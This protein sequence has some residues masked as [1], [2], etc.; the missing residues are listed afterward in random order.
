MQRRTFIQVVTAAFLGTSANVRDAYSFSRPKTNFRHG[1]ASG[2][3]THDGVIIWTRVTTSTVGTAN[4]RWQVASDIGMRKVVRD[5]TFE[6][7]ESRDFTVKVDVDGL[8]AGN[9][10]FYRF[11]CDGQSSTVGKTRTLPRGPVNQARFAVVSCSNYPAGYFN[12][13]REIAL[14]DDLDAVLHLGDYIYEYGMGEYATENAESLGRVPEPR[15]EI[16]TLADYRQRHAQYKTDPDSQS[17][18]A[19]LPVIAIW[20]DHEFANDSWRDGAQNHQPDEGGWQSRRDAA[21]QAYFEWM[22]VRGAADGAAT[23]IYR[24]FRWGDLA[25]IFMLD[26]RLVGRDAQPNAGNEVSRDSIVAPDSAKQRRLLGVEQEDW[27]RTSLKGATDTAWQLIG[28]QVMVS[29]MET[30][31]LEPLV[32]RERSP[33]FSPEQMDDVI[34][35]SKSHAPQVLDVWEGYPIAREDFLRD[36]DEYAVNP[37]VLSGDFHTSMAG[38]LVPSG[39]DRPVAV[40]LMTGAVS[41]P[42]MSA[43]L[44]DKIPNGVRDATLAQNP[45]IRFLDIAHRGWLSVALTADKC[46]G[47]WHLVDTVLSRDYKTWK[48]ASLSVN[49]GEIKNGLA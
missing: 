38:N 1:V 6:T 2:D 40:E 16:R 33:F 29:R 21:L 20:D 35:A 23:R 4:V 9:D 5:G 12:V 31:D 47:E 32:D 17:M 27:L 22:P 45:N 19:A 43:I 49:A 34:K 13:Y 28:Q 36:L 24:A 8:S 39:G 7:G 25:S 46:T 3:P 41:S 14:Q 26:T 42:G 30:P 37:V 11:S 18:H 44:P 15:F 10:Y 48:A